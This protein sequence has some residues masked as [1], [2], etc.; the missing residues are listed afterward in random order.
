MCLNCSL[1]PENEVFSIL[2]IYSL[3]KHWAPIIFSVFSAKSEA[4]NDR[5]L[6]RISARA[7]LYF[8]NLRKHYVSNALLVRVICTGLNGNLKG[9]NIVLGNIL[10]SLHKLFYN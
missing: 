5:V 3:L 6:T 2:H 7:P 8:M 10:Y 4:S 1:D 9:A